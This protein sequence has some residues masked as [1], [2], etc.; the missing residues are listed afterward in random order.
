[1]HLA[2]TPQ[3]R[4]QKLGLWVTKT[5]SR[6][7]DT[8]HLIPIA[9]DAGF[10]R[11]FRF[12]TPSQWLAVDAP[13]Q[14]EDTQQF[15]S[16][17]RYLSAN[18]VNTPTI[19]AADEKSG[20]LLVT[21]FGDE[22][23]YRTLTPQTFQAGY[24][25]TFNSLLSLQACADQPALIPRYDRALLRRELDIFIE[26]FTGRLLSYPLQNAEQTMLH[27]LFLNLENSAL[28]QPQT[29][30][31]RDFHSRNLLVCADESIGVIDF[32]G[33]LWGGCTYDL[34]SLLK[35]CYIRWPAAQT[36]ELALEYYRL[37]MKANLLNTD[38]SESTYLRWFDWMGLQRH[39]KVLGIFA[40]LQLRDN[41]PH[42]LKDLPLVIRYTLEVAQAYPELTPF[43]QWFNNKLLPLI[44]QQSWYS[45]YRLAGE[46]Q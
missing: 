8:I 16:L 23:L 22:L 24:R 19:L 29:L 10:R 37:A 7:P 20:F 38:V 1:M 12:A 18:K 45:D 46:Q 34:V 13:P 5:L 4:E 41:K 35:D 31:H 3:E 2:L 32:Q 25:Q 14:T 44:E 39:I 6:A 28:E 11:Y 42:Y 17:A 9:S 21:D 15:V 40:R 26:W 36:R 33:A 43:G 27:E 30:V